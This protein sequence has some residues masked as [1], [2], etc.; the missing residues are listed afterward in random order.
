[1]QPQEISI[2]RRALDVEDYIDVARRHRG[3]IVGPVF[4]GLVASVV[5][6]YLW[7]DTY[8]SSAIIKVIP[9]QVPEDYVKSNISQLMSDRIAALAGQVESR[10]VLATMIQTL[11]LYPKERSKLPMEDIVE[12]M[13]HDISI[14]GVASFATA[15]N[16]RSVPAFLIQFSYTE[17]YKAQKVVSE[18]SSKFIDQSYRDR[19]TGSRGTADLLR[20][21]HARAKAEMEAIDNRLAAFRQ[22]N[23]GKLPEE[24]M[25]NMQAYTSLQSQLTNLNSMISRISNDKIGYETNI[26]ILKDSIS[27]IKEPPAVETPLPKSEKLVQAEREV[28]YLEKQ[29]T[30]MREHYRDTYPPLQ[31]AV[32][33]LNNA[34]RR[35]E[36]AQKED[37]ARKPEARAANPAVARDVRETETRIKQ[38]EGAMRQKDLEAEEYKKE[39]ARVNTLLHTY[40]NRMQGIPMSQKESTELT[41]ASDIARQKFTQL[42]SMVNRS[43]LADEME[44][45][46][47]GESL[48]VLDPASLPHDPVQPKRPIWIGVGTVMGLFLGFVLAGAREMKDTS[49]K[50]LKDVRAYTQLPIL[51][52]VPLLE[53][54]LVVR[55]RRRIAWLAWSFAGLAGILL[56]A[57]SII[58]YYTTR[59]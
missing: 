22:Q 39:I 18:L 32:S 23:A 15:A 51:G 54:D 17:R 9:Q 55:R 11:D 59:T 34:K 24:Q 58:F 27:A 46:R 53:N 41:R 30:S 35:K 29:V 56:M 45:R 6:A 36:Q 28:D 21:E 38:I 1:M 2:S 5:A 8:T 47:F 13:K 57:G 10:A 49:L 26:K 50:N 31:N 4:A 12:R 48:E 19:S 16:S 43:G 37:D 14:S 7:P 25:G 3:W 42:D 52:S 33:E 20:D 44:K 40:E